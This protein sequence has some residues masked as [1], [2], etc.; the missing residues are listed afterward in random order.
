MKK[1]VLSGHDVLCKIFSF[2]HCFTKSY[3][4]MLYVE[5]AEVQV[6][7]FKSRRLTRDWNQ[8]NA[9]DW[10]LEVGSTQWHDLHIILLPS[11]CRKP[12]QVRKIKLWSL[13][14]LTI[15]YCTFIFKLI[16]ISQLHIS[17]RYFCFIAIL[18]KICYFRSMRHNIE[19]QSRECS[20][21]LWSD[22]PM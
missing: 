18:A 2:T 19:A 1:I 11:I 8:L 6:I 10:N 15:N 3:K 12:S 14:K 4:K 21:T 7:L 20:T 22:T 9:F 16:M 13:S 17:L 5:M